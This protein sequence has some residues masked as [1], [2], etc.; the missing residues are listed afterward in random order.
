[1]LMF[2]F[3]ILQNALRA[4]LECLSLTIEE[5]MHIRSVLTKAE[6]ECMVLQQELQQQLDKG[7]VSKI[8]ILKYLKN[9]VLPDGR[10]D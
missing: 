4:S 2:F 9:Y 1:M 3:I 8:L 5:V 6:L 7:K 10:R